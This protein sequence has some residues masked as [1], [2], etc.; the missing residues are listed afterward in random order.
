[1]TQVKPG[2]WPAITKEF[3]TGNSLRVISQNPDN[4][5]ERTIT[6]HE[7][8]KY[9]VPTVNLTPIDYVPTP[10]GNDSDRN[11]FVTDPNAHRWYIDMLGNAIRFPESFEMQ[12]NHVPLAYVPA[13]T[14][15]LLN[16]NQLVTASDG[17]TWFIDMGGRGFRLTITSGDIEITDSASGVIHKDLS[18][19]RHRVRITEFGSIITEKL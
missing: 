10:S 4:G 9:I 14:G 5:Q 13:A 19:A 17:T 12:I 15:N 8:R 3:L 16:L 1:M 11:S 6:E 7:L 2:T 18:A